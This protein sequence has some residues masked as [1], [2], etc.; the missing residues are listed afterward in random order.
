MDFASDCSEN[1][2]IKTLWDIVLTIDLIASLVPI[3]LFP[4]IFFN[5]KL[6]LV[7]FDFISLQIGNTWILNIDSTLVIFF[8]GIVVD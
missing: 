4:G 7:F 6:K 5:P 2:A 8:D 1:L 3:K